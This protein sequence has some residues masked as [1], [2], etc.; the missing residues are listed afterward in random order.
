M[1]LAREGN[2]PLAIEHVQAGGYDVEE[3][4]QDVP[5]IRRA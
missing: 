4:R 1:C 3:F 5:R 2:W